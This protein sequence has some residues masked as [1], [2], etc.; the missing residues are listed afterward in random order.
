MAR[1]TGSGLGRVYWAVLYR[2][3]VRVRVRVLGLG[4]DVC[5]GGGDRIVTLGGLFHLVGEKWVRVRVG[6][7]RAHTGKSYI[8]S[9]LALGLGLGSDVCQ[10]GGDRTVTLSGVFHLVGER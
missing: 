9:G 2:V 10:G 8:G 4:S 7:V 3:T 6:L 5:Q 1:A